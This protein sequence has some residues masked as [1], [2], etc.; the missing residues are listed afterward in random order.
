MSRTAIRICYLIDRLIRGGTELRLKRLIEGLDRSRFEP[1]LCLLDGEDEVSR[2]LEPTWL[3]V[4][5]L[6]I[7][8]LRHPGTALKFLQLVRFLRRQRIQIAEL[9]FPDSTTLGVPAAHFAGVPHV[10]TTCFNLQHER[11]SFQ[12]RRDRWYRSWV[13]ATITNCRAAQELVQAALPSKMRDRVT[14]LE[15]GIDLTPFLDV[16]PLRQE[17][18]QGDWRVGM[19]ANLRPVKDPTLFVRA[20]QQVH[21]VFPQAQFFLAGTGPSTQDVTSLAAELGIGSQ[22]HVVGEVTNVAQFLKTLDVCV[23]CSRGEGMSNA[24]IE[25]MAAARPIVVTAAGGNVELIQ[26][27]IN[28]LVV[29]PQDR[30]ALADGIIDLLK[31]R[32]AANRLAESARKTAREK[33]SVEAMVQ[34]FQAFY[35]ELVVR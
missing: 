16:P 3:P 11:T 29:P 12:W 34:R 8:R 5:R 23:L 9:Y 35:E 13:S 26:D 28:G 24:V 30:Q 33:F 10:V 14:V 22:L 19:V 15:N 6:G 17:A 31:N 7:R 27:R 18:T 2:S 1:S 20:A 25:Y 32:L 21:Q 4:L